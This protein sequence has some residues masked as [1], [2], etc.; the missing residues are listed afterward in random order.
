MG[1]NIEI[2]CSASD[3]SLSIFSNCIVNTGCQQTIRQYFPHQNY[4]LYSSSFKYSEEYGSV[5]M[6]VCAHVYLCLCMHIWMYVV[7]LYKIGYV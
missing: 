2:G 4:A 3:P 1:A 5:C 7:Q 6:C